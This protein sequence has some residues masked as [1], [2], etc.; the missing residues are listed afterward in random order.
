VAVL[1]ADEWKGQPDEAHR[2][3]LLD[4]LLAPFWEGMPF[5]SA[6]N[7]RARVPLGPEIWSDHQI[8]GGWTASDEEEPSVER[9]QPVM[10]PLKQ[11]PPPPPPVPKEVTNT[12]GIRR[13]GLKS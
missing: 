12:D 2:R 3:A 5:R 4:S 13:W 1:Y 10:L 9:R 7:R 11:S 6:D 8:D